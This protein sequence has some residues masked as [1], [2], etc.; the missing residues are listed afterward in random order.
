MELITLLI[1]IA[2][3]YLLWQRFVVTDRLEAIDERRR[4]LENDVAELMTFVASLPPASAPS[5]NASPPP[6]SSAAAAAPTV[7]IPAKRAPLP[8]LPVSP[9]P[10]ASPAR[11]ARRPVPLAPTSAVGAPDVSPAPAGALSMWASPQAPATRRPVAPA[12]PSAAERFLER[13]GLAPAT[14]G[15]GV[16]RGAV[17]AW[18]E[19]RMLAVVGGIALVL[20]AV[21]FL[22][23]AFS[24]GWI[25]EPMRA[26]IGLAGGSLAIG[27]GELAFVRLRGIVGHVLLA[28][29]LSVVSLSLFAATRLYGLIAPE[30]GVAAALLAA[31][32]AAAIAIR[33]DSEVVAAFALVSVLA[34]PPLLGAPPTLLTILFLGVALVGT[35]AIAL[36]RTWVWLPPLA[37]VLAAP[38][39]ASATGGES[40]LSIALLTVIGFW[41]LNTIAAG[42]EEIRHP[43]YRLQPST[44]TLLLASAA[45]T[46]W[47]GFQVLDG[48]DAGSRGAFVAALA[49]GYLG[50][51]LGLL[52][53]FGDRHPF[54]LIVAATGVAAMTMAVPIQFGSMWVPVAWAAE[55]VALTLV[56]VRFRHP[57][58]AT[59]ALVLGAMSLTHLVAIEY[60]LESI[61]AGLERTRP[62]V[63]SEAVTFLFLVAAAV[64]AGVIVPLRWVR[65]A[66]AIVAVLVTAYV[67]PFEASGTLLVAAWSL[68]TVAAMVA[69]QYA[70]APG[71]PVGFTDGVA[72]SLR[73]PA[74]AAPVE[75]LVATISWL[76]R[77][78]FAV[79]AAVPI[80]AAAAHLAAFEYPARSL[81]SQ[82]ITGVPYVSIEGAAAAA[83]IGGLALAGSFASRQAR[84]AWVGIA[85]ILVSYTLAFE[86]LAPF[87]MIPWA[88]VGLGSLAIVRRLVSLEPALP[89]TATLGSLAERVP[90]AAAVG[91]FLCMAVDGLLYAPPSGF[92][93]ALAGQVA[94]P[95][96]PLVDE[97]TFALLVLAMSL[98]GAGWV[99]AGLTARAVGAVAAALTIAWL[100]PFEVRPAYA[101]AGW[102]V[103]ASIGFA[104]AAGWPSIRTIVGGP[105]IGLLGFGAFVAI[106]VIAPP[107]RLVVDATT[108]VGGY[109]VLTEA[110]V[111]LV[112]LA[113][114]C[115]VGVGLHRTDRL[116]PFG[117]LAAA[118]LLLY[119]ISVGVVDVFQQQVGTRPLEDLQREAQLALSLVWSTLGVTTF[120]IGLLGQ[121]RPVRRAGLALLGLATAKV[122][123]VD[124]ASLD[125]AYR[126][127]SLVGLGVVLLVGAG[128][129]ARQQQRDSPTEA[130]TEA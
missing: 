28:V 18:L 10:A 21:F 121:L 24:R 130:E 83:V 81:G 124:L 115:A 92:L 8:T 117:A 129:Y 85:L 94:L 53:R 89:G 110:T 65:V 93:A 11:A 123:I 46:V 58:A 70:V 77:P 78:S 80:T 55:A 51:A 16:S 109:P 6:T 120:V 56:A 9:R 126:V 40:S 118:L 42:G 44:V 102:A 4:R 57:Y 125:L 112:S 128:I 38:Q 75:D 1:G 41:L 39:V 17:E 25:T 27:L 107:S 64:V 104:I 31:I 63:G 48:G 108:V 106:T 19:G 50:L 2:T 116:S 69:W 23:L 76:A 88:L 20:G 12:G 45:F 82:V 97:R 47:A 36:Y 35:T 34:A 79:T 74:W 100:L 59:A 111:A 32:V 22:S 26:L 67:L 103:L 14:D 33:H 15:Q 105:A 3:L 84:M 61:A 49:L 86:V 62:F 30:A 13:I 101:V 122:F 72:P 37:F 68:L 96:T 114:A 127:L 43:A 71:I 87:V 73:L 60:P 99:W 119:A 95:Q 98:V 29:G 5:A 7:P 113:V 90:F 91:A 54:G 66:L 52:I